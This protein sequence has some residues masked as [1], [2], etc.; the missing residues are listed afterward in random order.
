MLKLVF[1]KHLTEPILTF[2]LFYIIG[3]SMKLNYLMKGEMFQAQTREKGQ[4]HL[5]KNQPK[6]FRQVPRPGK[7]IK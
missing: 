1:E 7:L 3:Q 6:L 4:H 5:P 2:A